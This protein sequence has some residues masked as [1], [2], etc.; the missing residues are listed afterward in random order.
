MIE[1]EKVIQKDDFT[2]SNSLLDIC[3]ILEIDSAPELWNL[4]YLS[5]CQTRK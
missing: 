1:N 5:L 3:E 4:R 2:A